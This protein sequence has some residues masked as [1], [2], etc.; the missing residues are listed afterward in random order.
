MSELADRLRARVLEVLALIGD[1]EA[2]RKYQENVPHVD[3]PAELFNQWE[4]S[5]FPA[6]DQFRSAFNDA[7]LDALRRFDLIVDEVSA[8]TPKQLPPLDAFIRT[9]AWQRLS[10]GAR[11]ALRD[12]RR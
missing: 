6:D 12:V 4:E 11:A 5:F 8:Q 1:R 10:E 9:D 7:E 2:Q 3:V